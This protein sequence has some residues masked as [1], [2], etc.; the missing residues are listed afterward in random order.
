MEQ[1]YALTQWVLIP[2]NITLPLEPIFRTQHFLCMDFILLVAC[3]AALIV[4]LILS[5]K[6]L[7]NAMSYIQTS[8]TRLTTVDYLKIVSRF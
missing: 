7:Y 3:H 8:F 1:Q 5:S 4:S 2:V 6:C